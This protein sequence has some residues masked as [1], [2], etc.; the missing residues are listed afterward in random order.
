MAIEVKTI[1]AGTA[2]IG[3]TFE[4]VTKSSKEF[5]DIL[6]TVETAARWEKN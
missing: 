4:V 1:M 3:D 5:K 6:N 2:I